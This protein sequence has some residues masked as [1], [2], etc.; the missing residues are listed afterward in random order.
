M[1]DRAGII[2]QVE[3]G[4]RVTNL[5][6]SVLANN[7]ANLETPQFRR[8]DIRFDQ[9][10]ADAIRSGGGSDLA[11]LSPEVIQPKDTPV[12]AGG[13]DVSMDMEMGEL[14]KNSSRYKTLMR[15]MSKMY[16]QMAQAMQGE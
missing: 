2:S 6:Q 3:A 8:G 4:L 1:A 13:N 14:L 11:E 5:R 9:E 7:I 15:V 10:L 16:Q 12:S